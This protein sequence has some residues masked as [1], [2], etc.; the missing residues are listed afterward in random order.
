MAERMLQAWP[1][2]VVKFGGSVLTGQAAYRRCAE[3]IAGVLVEF[4]NDRIVAVVSA[5]F[6]VTDELADVARKITTEPDSSTL[7]LLWATGELRSVAILTL[8]LQALGIEAVALN[9]HQCGLIAEGGLGGDRRV[10]MSQ[11]RL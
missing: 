4:P 5:E 2:T 9:A 10:A 7:D 3:F 6:G 11:Q 8:C 1:I